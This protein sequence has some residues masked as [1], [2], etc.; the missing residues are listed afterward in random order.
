MRMAIARG[1]IV[2]N[3]RKEVCLV[4]AL[5]GLLLG[6]ARAEQPVHFAD[7][8]VKG[9]VEAELWIT[10]PTPTDM[11]GLTELRCINFG[12]PENGVSSIEGLQYA[13]NL[14]SLDLRLNRVSD[15]SPLSGLVNLRYLSLSRNRVGNLSGLSGLVNLEYL[16]LHGNGI[17]DISPL[18][19]LVHLETLILRMNHI[20]DLA[21]LS[22]LTDLRTLA[23]WDNQISDISPLSQLTHLEDLEL[24]QNNITDISALLGL[25]SLTSLDLRA[26]PWSEEV[27]SVYVPQLM[28]SNPGINI[29]HGCG[30]F[31]LVV[32][33]GPGGSVLQP[34][35]GQFTREY[36]DLVTLE[37]A[38]GAG[39]IFLGWS[40]TQISQHNP[41]YIVIRGDHTVRANF[42]STSDVL[43]VDD[44]ASGDP[45][46]GDPAE[47]D[48]E[49]NGTRE[50]PFD[51]IQEAVDVAMEGA[52]ICVRS[53][54]YRENID[55]SGKR[56]VLTGVDWD[57]PNRIGWPTLDGMDSGPSVR[58]AGGGKAGCTLT[59]FVI[60]GG[61]SRSAG[62]IW[63]SHADLRIANCLIAGN[64]A[65]DSGGV[66]VYCTDANAVLT[67]CTIADNAVLGEGAALYLQDSRVTVVNSILWGNAPVEIAV[68]GASEVSIRYSDIADGW[69]GLHNIAA[70]PLFA[71][72]G[73]WIRRGY[74]QK[75]LA[76]EY[77]DATWLMGD[78]HLQ[79]Q[80]GRWDPQAQEWVQDK[81]T[82]PS[83]DGGDPN[84]SV[85]REPV[86]NG[87]I[88]N[89]G[90]YGGTAE[91]GKSAPHL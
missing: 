23:I 86:P 85:G 27:C 88:I 58:L 26:N 9:A 53:G 11:L 12:S 46:G 1:H 34:G 64:R 91:A 61:R 3:T 16:D 31:S 8:T 10:D 13:A 47:S 80:A 76:P 44:D 6:T 84:D 68:A 79:S 54:T 22:T 65:T 89:M 56:L 69:P 4:L 38:P 57:D 43:Y 18:S 75:A 24:A 35:Q 50:H 83:I 74:P 40:G 37:A 42:A 48:P 30:P 36:D 21:P 67:N 72:A 15:I 39:F 28:A 77:P 17:S 51:R 55:L 25:T 71:V 59:G 90:A 29:Q 14:Q 19:S 78:Y 82:S 70:S 41:E 87:D 5:S 45:R 62:A 2:E 52:R 60:T 81:R 7:L 63:C 33:A 73:H 20:S 32:S 66:A 49:E